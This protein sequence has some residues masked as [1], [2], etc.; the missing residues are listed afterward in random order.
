VRIGHNTLRKHP[1]VNDQVI[2]FLRTHQPFAPDEDLTQDELD[3]FIEF[4][5]WLDESKDPEVVPWLLR[6]FGDGDGAGTYQT[7]QSL[8]RTFPPESLSNRCVM[9]CDPNLILYANGRLSFVA[10]CILRIS[11]RTSLE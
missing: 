4:L 1:L 11:F 8:L 6:S 7:A 9:P 3:T 2:D 5:D 10:E